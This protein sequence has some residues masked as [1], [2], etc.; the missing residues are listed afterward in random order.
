MASLQKLAAK[1]GFEVDAKS[2]D[3]AIRSV[4]SVDREIKSLS[5]SMGNFMSL[6]GAGGVAAGLYS[7]ARSAINS[8][9]QQEDAVVR[10][11][12]A[13]RNLGV[14]TD[15][16]IKRHSEFADQLQRTTKF[17]DDA[18]LQL[19]GLLSAFGLYGDT[20]Q[21]A[22]R[23]TL[24]L[25]SGLGIDLTAAANL[26]GKAFKGQT[27]TLSRYGIVIKEGLVGTEKFDEVLRVVNKT[28]SGMAQEQA[29]SVS[30]SLTQL[31]NK[32]DDINERI[33][34]SL[35]PTLKV[36]V[37]WWSKFGDVAN[38]ALDK[39][40]S[41]DKIDVLRGELED[42]NQLISGN[43][44]FMERMAKGYGL[45]S[46]VSHGYLKDRKK[47]LEQEIS[48]LIATSPSKSAV[49]RPTLPVGDTAINDL[50]DQV[51]IVDSAS[52]S[53]E[54]ANEAMVQYYTEFEGKNYKFVAA[55]QP[56]AE[57]QKRVDKDTW[58]Q[59]NDNWR[60]AQRENK[61]TVEK[62]KA[63]W[64]EGSRSIAGGWAQ[65]L[66]LM[67]QS[68]SNWQKNWTTVMN[69]SVG[70]AKAAF[71]DFFSSTSREF[72]DLGSL[73]KKVFQGILDAFLDMLEMMAAKAAIYGIFSLAG[74]PA[75]G[76][77]LMKFLGFSG[78]G[79][80]GDGNP[81]DIAGFVHKGEYVLDAET[82]SKIRSGAPVG[83]APA[84][85][86][87]AGGKSVNITQNIT[88]S[89]SG[90][91]EDIGMLCE[92]IA[93]ATR[94]GVRQAGEMANVIT[95]IGSKKSGITGL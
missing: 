33:G 70:P 84:L 32:F 17:S 5:R 86:S 14:Y 22:T 63:D 49:S 81:K 85:A 89:G 8:Y 16:E 29:K 91:P 38:W 15:D 46:Y 48:T 69:A 77:G 20:L 35:I 74:G 57:L 54:R 28:M 58:K 7:F 40:K 19:M 65:A 2:V 11:S 12:A 55:I 42:I 88:L 4:N 79:Y 50:S 25:S 36:A 27:E 39:L 26:I 18:I 64:E 92:K 93:E 6:L 44:T 75:S 87:A 45:L 1:F 72:L 9:Q 43:M 80:T 60:A 21:R 3:T 41:K 53:W 31:A 10:L 51:K 68:A 90:S 83:N 56:T 59:I 34:E 52:I 23:A 67:Q 13:M 95:K 61:N 94:T 30:G 82:T 37:E 62:I 24:D 71:H 66:I 76:A 78:G 73:A 47:Q